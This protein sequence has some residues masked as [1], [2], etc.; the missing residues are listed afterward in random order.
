MS[1]PVPMLVCYH[2]KPGREDELLA[3][4]RRHWPVLSELGLVT[5][6]P[7]RIYRATDKR[8]DRPPYF[9]ELFAWKDESSSGVAHQTPEVMAVW[10][11][12]GEVMAELTLTH[13]E[14]CS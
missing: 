14:A 2:P 7:A 4:V 8:T 9:V 5:D 6:E 11:P 10:E 1:N 3:L 12:M 13:L